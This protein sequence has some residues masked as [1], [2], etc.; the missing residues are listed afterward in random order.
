MRCLAGLV[1]GIALTFFAAVPAMAGGGPVAAD[2]S[3]AADN[4][5]A[6]IDVLANDTA[7]GGTLDTSTLSIVSAP[8]SGEATVIA[9]GSPKVKYTAAGSAAMVDTFRYE[10]CD[11]AGACATATVTVNF[12]GEPVATTTTTTIVAI[13]TPA[14][15]PEVTP[16]APAPDPIVAPVAEPPASTGTTAAPESAPVTTIAPSA[17]TPNIHALGELTIASGATLAAGTTIGEAR[18]VRVGEDVAYLG[19][20][21]L[22]TLALVATPALMLSGVVGFLMI[23]LPQNALSSAFGFLVAWRRGKKAPRSRE[24]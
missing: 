21:G 16:T 2:D 5:V 12:G 23:G 19:R 17:P 15:P 7:S 11:T 6:H 14:P 13:T 24:A 8:S 4:K 18:G 22:D 20:T 3:V 9:S 1:G 10:I